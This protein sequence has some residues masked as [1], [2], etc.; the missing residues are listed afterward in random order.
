MATGPVDLEILHTTATDDLPGYVDQLRG[1][2]VGL[3]VPPGSD[4]AG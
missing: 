3:E 4:S 2:L 1:V